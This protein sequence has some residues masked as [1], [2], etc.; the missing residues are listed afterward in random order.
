MG[1]GYFMGSYGHYS[2]YSVKSRR[3][4][5]STDPGNGKSSCGVSITLFHA[6]QLYFHFT[7]L[8]DISIWPVLTAHFL[9]EHYRIARI[10]VP[11]LV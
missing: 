5:V 4:P 1:Y 11:V 9:P 6:Q 7:K 10:Q 3:K 8:L 2:E